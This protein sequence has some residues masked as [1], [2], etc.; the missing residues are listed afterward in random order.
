MKP[1]EEHAAA[2]WLFDLLGVSETRRARVVM[3]LA[4]MERALSLLLPVCKGRDGT[5]GCVCMWWWYSTAAVWAPPLAQP[6]FW[7]SPD[8]TKDM[9]LLPKVLLARTTERDVIFQTVILWLLFKS[10]HC[11]YRT[12]GLNIKEEKK[13]KLKQGKM[14]VS[15]KSIESI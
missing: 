15:K 6:L 14:C 7:I 4:Q 12:S 1:V 2:C 3:G 10:V 9:N 11:T 5:K 8:G 13:I